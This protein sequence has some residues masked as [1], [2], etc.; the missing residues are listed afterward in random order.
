MKQVKPP[1]RTSAMVTIWPL[2][3][4]TSRQSLL[5]RAEV[6]MRTSPAE[7]ARGGPVLDPAFPLHA[8]VRE[9]HHPIGD[10]GNRRVVSNDGGRGA[11]LAVDALDHV[12]NENSRP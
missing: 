7:L 9:R 1:A 12:E 8:T 2:R 5:S 6:N 4:K 10:V 11:E 3:R